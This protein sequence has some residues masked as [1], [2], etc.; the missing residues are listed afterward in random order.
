MVLWLVENGLG[1]N[2]KRSGFGL[3][4]ELFWPSLG[5]TGEKCKI[6][7]LGWSMLD[8]DTDL[9]PQ[10]RK[11]EALAVDPACSAKGIK[12][13]KVL[14]E[15]WVSNLRPV[16]LYCVVLRYIRKIFLYY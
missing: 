11:S 4:E 9:A 10:E 15:K 12:E 16:C 7:Q 1:E 6:N 8:R 2:L 13:S 3:S 5:R 14:L